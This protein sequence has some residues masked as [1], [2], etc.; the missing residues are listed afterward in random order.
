MQYWGIPQPTVAELFA[1][2]RESPITRYYRKKYADEVFIRE[3]LPNLS[4]E[5]LRV[6]FIRRLDCSAHAVISPSFATV[7]PTPEH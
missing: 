6:L 3:A 7:D 2:S 4:A 5:K 1:A